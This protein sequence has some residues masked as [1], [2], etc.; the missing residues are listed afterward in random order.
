[1]TPVRT[2]WIFIGLVIAV[3]F[4][5]I[6][7]PS[8]SRAD[9]KPPCSGDSTA[10]QLLRITQKGTDPASGAHVIIYYEDKRTPRPKSINLELY[11][12]KSKSQCNGS[13]SMTIANVNEGQS[14]LA[15]SMATYAD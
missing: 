10:C 6:S 12:A 15:R 3:S 14:G 13:V 8:Q 1:M 4:V 11:L 2:V 7:A 9:D 5:S